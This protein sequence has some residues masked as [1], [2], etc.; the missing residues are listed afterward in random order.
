MQTKCRVEPESG[1]SVH[2]GHVADHVL[3]EAVAEEEHG[4]L[5]DVGDEGRGGAL[6][7]AA[8]P[9]LSAGAHEA[10]HEAP[11]HGGKRLHLHLGG[12]EGLPAEHAG[13]AALGQTAAQDMERLVREETPTKLRYRS[14]CVLKDDP[15]TAPA[16]KSMIA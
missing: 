1:P 13:R 15:P 16:E 8:Q 12:V 9:H 7:E 14:P 10:V 5:A 6:V 2:P 11:V 3:A 4:V